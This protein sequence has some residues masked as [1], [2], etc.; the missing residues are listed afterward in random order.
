MPNAYKC[1]R[2]GSYFDTCVIER[3][4]NTTYSKGAGSGTLINVVPSGYL[5][6]I[7]HGK[8]RRLIELKFTD[9]ARTCLCP[10]CKMEYAKIIG[11]W[12]KEGWYGKKEA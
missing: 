3:L 8:E 6:E 5:E 4:I 11:D 12:F 2:C 7:S 10:R 9:S 1:D